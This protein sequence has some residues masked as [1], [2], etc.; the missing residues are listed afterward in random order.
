MKLKYSLIIL[1]LF[2]I[3]HPVFAQDYSFG[4]ELSCY[5]GC[6]GSEVDM[7]NEI[8]LQLTIKN[9]YPYWISLGESSYSG[10]P[11][12]QLTYE[13]SNLDKYDKTENYDSLFSEEIFLA[14]KSKYELYF[15]LTTFNEL[16]ATDRIGDWAI[17]SKFYP[18]SI[19]YYENPF[20][21]KEAN[22]GYQN[23]IDSELTTTQLKFEVIGENISINKT[24]ATGFFEWIKNN[25]N[26]ILI[27]L[28][29]TV[30][31]GLIL[32]AITKK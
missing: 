2:I 6:E 4:Y 23:K 7:N 1:G 25:G 14:P 21:G 30:L 24:P 3:I 10:K 29:V 17:K 26:T 5:Q 19:T 9:N 22:I 20:S 28:I 27:G 18:S 11:R 31:G 16:D 12:L 15:P 8:I 13:N 32:F